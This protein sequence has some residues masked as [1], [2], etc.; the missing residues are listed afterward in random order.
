MILK[1]N[2]A[3]TGK[4]FASKQILKFQSYSELIT[5][6]DIMNLFMGLVKLIKK[7][8]EMKMEAKYEKEIELLKDKLNLIG[9]Y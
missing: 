9:K 7:S 4:Y 2:Y 1:P 8:T 6:E 5:D 3:L